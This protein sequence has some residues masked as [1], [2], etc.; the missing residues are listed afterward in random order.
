MQAIREPWALVPFQALG[1]VRFNMTR[2]EVEDVLGRGQQVSEHR[3]AY[4]AAEAQIEYDDAGRVETITAYPSRPVVVQDTTLQGEQAV[5]DMAAVLERLGH[6]GEDDG[7]GSM[8]Y[9]ALGLALHAPTG[10]VEGVFAS[11]EA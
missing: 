8:V 6:Q 4:D 7:E 11:R 9:A 1:P 2:S 5:T 10:T 3:V